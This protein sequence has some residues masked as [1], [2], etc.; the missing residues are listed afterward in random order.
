MS[1]NKKYVVW[2]DETSGINGRYRPTTYGV[3]IN[4]MQS[5]QYIEEWKGLIAPT[6]QHA[7]NKAD[8][9]NNK[10]N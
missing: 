1:K 5:K 7:V 9:L 8:E 10:I 3:Y 2:S 6:Y 4:D